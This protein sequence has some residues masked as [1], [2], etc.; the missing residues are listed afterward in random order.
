MVYYIFVLDGEIIDLDSARTV[1]TRLKS[2]RYLKMEKK[3]GF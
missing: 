1:S 3:N 2:E